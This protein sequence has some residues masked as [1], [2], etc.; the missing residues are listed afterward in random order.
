MNAAGP[1][2]RERFGI[3]LPPGA[4]A[5]HVANSVHSKLDLLQW[6]RQLLSNESEDAI[7]R[8]LTQDASRRRRLQQSWSADGSIPSY[9]RQ[10]DRNLRRRSPNRSSL[11]EGDDD[12]QPP[13][14]PESPTHMAARA[15][16]RLGREAPWAESPER[17]EASLG[18]SSRHAKD[19][20]PRRHADFS[21][22]VL[23]Q[24]AAR[25]AAALGTLAREAR[26]AR[27]AASSSPDRSSSP[28]RNRPPSPPLL[29]SRAFY[30]SHDH[31]QE[32]QPD[33][34]GAG[35]AVRWH[36]GRK[37]S[38]IDTHWAAHM[39]PEARAPKA[40][41]RAKKERPSLSEDVAKTSALQ[42]T[43]SST[44]K[45]SGS[46]PFRTGTTAWGAPAPASRAVDPAAPYQ[47]PIRAPS[48]TMKGLPPGAPA[49]LQRQ[50]RNKKEKG[51]PRGS[52]NRAAGRSSSTAG[53]ARSDP[54]YIGAPHAAT[55]RSL[56]ERNGRPIGEAARQQPSSPEQTEREYISPRSPTPA[57]AA[58]S[59]S[60]F[61]P[62]SA[63]K[64]AAAVE[65]MRRVRELKTEALREVLHGRQ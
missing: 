51:T 58:S 14:S 34:L 13:S 12:Q 41:P 17:W 37:P 55:L 1:E 46:Y 28:P 65:V 23:D 39:M 24:V 21:L 62:S 43:L 59:S 56:T 10:L 54:F 64:A 45:K 29:D 6:I 27:E 18:G 61:R 40:A 26:Q 22:D 63:Y 52:G 15:A 38:K 8:E 33:G 48:P 57:T 9:A 2:V 53:S 25:E 31:H 7:G 35:D 30:I 11:L 60:S 19:E 32:L 47:I 4:Q 49:T 5:Q 50:S 36:L 20:R 44:S 3:R 16:A 42:P